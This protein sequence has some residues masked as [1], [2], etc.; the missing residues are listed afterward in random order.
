VHAPSFSDTPQPPGEPRMRV[1]RAPSVTR[2]HPLG[3]FLAGGLLALFALTAGAAT[4]TVNSTADIHDGIAGDG[5]CETAKNNHICTLRA[6]IDEA[7]ALDGAD[8]IQLQANTTYVLS[9]TSTLAAG[10]SADLVISDSVTLTGAGPESSIID[11]NGMVTDRGVLV[12]GQCIR[13]IKDTTGA[14]IF[15]NSTAGFPGGGQQPMYELFGIPAVFSFGA[16]VSSNYKMTTTGNPLLIFASRK[17]L[18]TG[19]RIAPQAKFISA[20]INVN[21]LEHTLQTRARVGF[22]AVIPQAFSVLEIGA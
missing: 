10:L 4:F 21:A 20:D 1:H 13:G 3:F 17:H 2:R 16:K 18:V 11:G 8:T 22:A 5:V 6:A 19:P 15:V 12:V 9:L 14:P 7:N